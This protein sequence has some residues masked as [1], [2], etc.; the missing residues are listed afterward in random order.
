M[1]VL[2][3]KHVILLI[4]ALSKF[5]VVLKFPRMHSYD[6]WIFMAK[7]EIAHSYFS[8]LTHCLQVPALFAAVESPEP[9]Y[10]IKILREP[11]LQG[12]AQQ[13][14]IL[15]AGA[16]CRKQMPLLLN[17]GNTKNFLTLSMTAAFGQ[18]YFFFFLHC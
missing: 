11:G 4:M 6:Q 9:I 17:S 16:I 12:S 2:H 15:T 7:K 5:L 1:C 18:W 3:H 8:C 13:G 14:L 10:K